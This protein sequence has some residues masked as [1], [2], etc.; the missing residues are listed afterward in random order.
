[1]TEVLDMCKDCKGI[2][3]EYLMPSRD[4]VRKRFDECV[5]ELNR[6]SIKQCLYDKRL[7]HKPLLQDRTITLSK[8]ANPSCEL[9]PLFRIATRYQCWNE[10]L[11][12]KC[13][14]KNMH[15]FDCVIN[16]CYLCPKHYTDSRRRER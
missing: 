3:R 5:K 8:C 1:M 15:Y 2:V 10:I 14:C 9:K 12:Y 16:H 4:T 13:E 7:F 6:Y 11:L